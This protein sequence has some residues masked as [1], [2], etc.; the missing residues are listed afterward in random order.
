MKF[1]K[2]ILIGGILIG[3]LGVA[4][5][6]KKQ[7]QKEDTPPIIDTEEPKNES[8]YLN[9]NVTYTSTQLETGSVEDT[10]DRI[11]DSVVAIDAYMNQQHYGSGSGVLFGYDERFSYIAT[12]HH[13]IEGCQGFKIILSNEEIYEAKLVG[14]DAESD[15]AVLSVEKTNLSYASWYEDTEKLRLGASVICIGNPLG[16]LPGSVSTGVVSYNNRVVQVDSYHSMKLI[17]TDVAINSGNSGGGLFNSAGALIGIVNAKYSSSGIEGL[18]FAIPENQAR[19]IIDNILKTAKYNVT[20]NEWETG[21]VEGRW[22]IGFTLGYGGFGFIRTNIGIASIAT[23][24]THSDYNKL[25][26]ND[27]LNAITITYKD[28]SKEIK[29]LTNITA[30]TTTLESI[31]QFIYSAGL[32]LGDVITFDITRGKENMIIEIPL[33]QYRYSI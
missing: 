5:C 22:E 32:S 6:S 9:L 4:S 12:C 18:G 27:R 1:W 8:E 11:Y 13:V 29:S 24:P 7:P 16:T 23:N 25:Q 33:V 26:V 20:E 3:T 14:G 31:Y 19:N 17:Q 21:F 30:Q 10:V 15:I 2:S 28:A